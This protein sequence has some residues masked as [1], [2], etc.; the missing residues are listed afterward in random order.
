MIARFISLEA[1]PTA[2]ELNVLI[3]SISVKYL[4]SM[5]FC[6]FYGTV[7]YIIVTQRLVLRSRVA[8]FRIEACTH[9]GNTQLYLAEVIWNE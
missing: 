8:V 3:T 6:I 2:T 1:L 7:D 5:E 4:S 9:S